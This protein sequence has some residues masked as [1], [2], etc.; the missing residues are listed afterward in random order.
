M[1]TDENRNRNGRGYTKYY[2]IVKDIA[3]TTGRA[4]GTIRNDISQGKLT[5]DDLRSVA[6]YIVGRK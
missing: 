3:E 6:E 2:Y 5:M 1:I 4:E